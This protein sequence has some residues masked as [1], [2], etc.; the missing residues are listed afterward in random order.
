[1]GVFALQIRLLA[2]GDGLCLGDLRI[3]FVERMQPHPF[4]SLADL[5]H[6]LQAGV[7]R[8]VDI[9]VVARAIALVMDETAGVA[10]AHPR[11]HRG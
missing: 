7:H 3:V 2:T 4:D 6:L 8:R 1:M 9:G 11:G 10:L 5:L